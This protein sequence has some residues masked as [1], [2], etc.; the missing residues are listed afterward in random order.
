MHILKLTLTIKCGLDLDGINLTQN[1]GAVMAVV[2]MVINLL[3]P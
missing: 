1:W 3:A 2:I